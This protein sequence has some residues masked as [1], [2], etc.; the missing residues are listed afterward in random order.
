MLKQEL[1]IVSL[2]PFYT[3]SQVILQFYVLYKVESGV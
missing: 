2:V 1:N 3:N